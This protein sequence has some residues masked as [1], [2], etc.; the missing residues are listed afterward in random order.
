MHRY[1]D[2]QVE[3]HSTN[4]EITLFFFTT[5]IMVMCIGIV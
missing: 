1:E 3:R 4:V 5:Y 2:A